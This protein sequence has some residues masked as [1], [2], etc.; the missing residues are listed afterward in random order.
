M[1]ALPPPSGVAE[2]G[3]WGTTTYVGPKTFA[4]AIAAIPTVISPFIILLFCPLDSIDV[5]KL[6]DKLYTADGKLYK[7]ATPHNFAIQ[8]SEHVPSGVPPGCSPNTSGAWGT[9]QHVGPLTWSAALV[10]LPTILGSILILL[11]MPLDNDDVYR[12]GNVLYLANGTK[13]KAASDN[14][15]D[16]RK[17]VHTEGGV[18]A[19]LA[20]GGTW[21]TTTYVGPLTFSLALGALPTVIGAILILLFLPLDQK[22]VYKLDEKLYLPSG[23]LFKAATKNNFIIRKSEHTEGTPKGLSKGEW[24]T[25]TYVGPLTFSLA[26]ISILSGVGWIVILLLLPLDSKEVYKMNDTLYLPD[27][28]QYKAASAHNFY[29]QNAKHVSAGADIEEEEV[30]VVHEDGTEALS[31]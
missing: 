5:Y 17:S 23:T 10:A 29:K 14:N 1:T 8:K 24:G 26:L 21:G 4:F 6:D 27:G 3:I 12:D 16:V 9:T 31:C 22:E 7:A 13:F 19:G 20:E 25:T 28:E 30:P 15:F 2:G 18:P 11:F